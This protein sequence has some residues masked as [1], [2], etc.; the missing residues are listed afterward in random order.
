VDSELG[1]FVP[2]TRRLSLMSGTGLQL[3]PDLVLYLGR[4][5]YLE[6]PYKFR[7]RSRSRLDTAMD[8][9]LL[10]VATAIKEMQPDF[11]PQREADALR[12]EIEFLAETEVQTYFTKSFN[13][14][15][16]LLPEPSKAYAEEVQNEIMARISKA[17]KVREKAG[18][19]FSGPK[20]PNAGLARR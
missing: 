10:E 1:D 18:D 2:Q 6:P 9:L 4:H 15:S 19:L 3:A 14:L 16:C 11:R 20:I 5:S 13:L 17:H 12:C 7:N 8:A